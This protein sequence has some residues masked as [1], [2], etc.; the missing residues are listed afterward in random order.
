MCV[1]HPT[2]RAKYFLKDSHNSSFCTDCALTIAPS[3]KK[4]YRIEELEEP[5]VSEFKFDSPNQEN[6]ICCYNTDI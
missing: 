1:N 2:K 5:E 4:L 3:A 6:S